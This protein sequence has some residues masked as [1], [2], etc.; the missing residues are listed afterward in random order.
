M[1]K[2]KSTTGFR[3]GFA[4]LLMM[5]CFSGRVFSLKLPPIAAEIPLVICT[6]FTSGIQPVTSPELEKIDIPGVVEKIKERLEINLK[7]LWAALPEDFPNASPSDYLG[8]WF[9]P[10]EQNANQSCQCKI[11]PTAPVYLL[12]WREPNLYSGRMKAFHVYWYFAFGMRIPNR[13][14]THTGGGSRT[15][16]FIDENVQFLIFFLWKPE[17]QNEAN[18]Q[19]WPIVFCWKWARNNDLDDQP[20][21]KTNR[22]GTGLASLPSITTAVILST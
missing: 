8:D 22:D 15:S 2:G 3:G 4:G 21:V 13:M 1:R 20:E 11:H 16:D 5:W 10:I 7:P 18:F 6:T 9:C 19:N 12:G 17:T 14:Y